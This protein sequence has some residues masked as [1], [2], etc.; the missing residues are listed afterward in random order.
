MSV[1][2]N[3][4]LVRRFFDAFGRNDFAALESV[5]SQDVVYH[6]APPGLSAGIEGYR[7][8][9]AMYVSA[10]PDIQIT[11]DDVIAE[12]DKVVTRYTSRGTHRGEFMGIAPTGS[13]VTV[14]GISIT[15]VAGNKVTEE[16]EQL[17]M[18]GGLQ[19]LGATLVPAEP[20]A[21]TA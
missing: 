10:F 14:G 5:T 3:K 16:W 8:L 2:E 4:A 9:M 13:Q 7:E 21:A 1:E 11:V 20:S 6:T 17:D 19:Q 18:L 15:R 12:G